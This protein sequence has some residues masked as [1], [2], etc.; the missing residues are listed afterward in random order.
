MPVTIPTIF[1]GRKV[2]YSSVDEI[3]SENLP[4]I[5]TNALGTHSANQFAIKYLEEY[6]RGRHPRILERVKTGRDD[7]Q[8]FVIENRAYEIVSFKTGYLM[9]E[10]V[11]YV[12]TSDTGKIEAIRKLNAYMDVEDK[13]TGDMELSDWWHICGTSF[14]MVLPD[15]RWQGVTSDES[16]FAVAT[17]HPYDTFV[18][19][20]SGIG[21]R[22]LAGVHGITNDDGQQIW[23]VWTDNKYFEVSGST[24]LKEEPNVIG[25]PII[26]YPANAQRLGAFEVVISLLDAI[27]ECDS[28]RVEGIEEFIQAIMILHN[29]DIEDKD[30][31]SLKQKGAIKVKDVDP[32]MQ[33]EIKYLVQELNQTQSQTLQD[34]LYETVL[35]ICG[36]P[37]RNM[38]SASTSDTG[39]ATVLRNGWYMAE[40][41]ARK[42][43][44]QFKKSEKEFL[45]KVLFICSIRD[46]L[47]LTLAD[48]GIQFTRRNYED[49]NG[50][51]NVLTQML[52]N[53]KID[54]LLAFVHCGLFSDPQTAYKQS[55]EYA[56]SLEA[57]KTRALE[58]DFDNADNHEDGDEA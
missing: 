14:R 10:P 13:C 1:T 8:A 18:I 5:M 3:T 46:P 11:Q 25:I 20:S 41:Y 27:D 52:N 15:E 17:L 30:F 6:Y 49:I 19:Y 45:K 47:D 9:G 44:M 26:E 58:E 42:S 43:E 34:H 37:N 40:S 4:T 33:G 24:V 38:G 48:I 53:D 35:T 29:V 50:K 57:E 55:M 31:A 32:S 36:M 2:I 21:H 22:P 28:S 51:A 16:P 23:S 39:K 54:P 12:S 7:I 56:A